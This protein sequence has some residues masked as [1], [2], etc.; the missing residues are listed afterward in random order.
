[1]RSFQSLTK[2][3]VLARV[4][5]SKAVKEGFDIGVEF[6]NLDAA[7]RLQMEKLFDVGEGPF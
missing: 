3:K 7:K 1:M 5:R 4:V 2:I 6:L